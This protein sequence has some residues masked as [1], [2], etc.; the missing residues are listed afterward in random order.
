[1][2]TSHQHRCW[3]FVRM[4]HCSTHWY[5]TY[6]MVVAA[7]AAA[8]A[9]AMVML[10]VILCLISSK[11]S[12]GEYLAVFV[13]VASMI[14]GIIHD[15]PVPLK[16]SWNVCVKQTGNKLV[17]TWRP[18]IILRM[19]V[20]EWYVLPLQSLQAFILH[21]YLAIYPNKTPIGQTGRE[22]NDKY[23]RVCCVHQVQGSYPW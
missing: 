20:I 1:M 9:A 14:S 19:Y 3:S 8:A 16:F 22:I 5:L 6:F 7:A 18:Y 15:F 10:S 4:I 13:W 23:M 12:F 21:T 11:V 17:Q 2:L